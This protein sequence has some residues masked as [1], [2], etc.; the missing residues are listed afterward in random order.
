MDSNQTRA[1]VFLFVVTLSSR[2]WGSLSLCLL[3]CWA[4][5]LSDNRGKVPSLLVSGGP[6][7]SLGGLHSFND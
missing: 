5:F 3:H 4:E 6:S 1:C 7:Q 2:T